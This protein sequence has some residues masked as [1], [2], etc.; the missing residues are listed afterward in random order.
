MCWDSKILGYK[1][2]VLCVHVLFLVAFR[3]AAIEFPDH[4]TYIRG[5]ICSSVSVSLRSPNGFL[6]PRLSVSYVHVHFHLPS[7]RSPSPTFSS[8]AECLPVWVWRLK[9]D[10]PKGREKGVWRV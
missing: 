8:R 4:P 9:W 10:E 5:Y 6:L 2:G 3:Q 1:Y 7:S